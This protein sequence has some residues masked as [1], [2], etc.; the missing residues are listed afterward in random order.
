MT[1]RAWILIANGSHA[2]LCFR[3]TRSAACQTMRRFEH[4]LSAVHERDLLT[5]RPGRFKQRVGKR[6]RAAAE[7]RASAKRQEALRF[8]RELMSSV[9]HALREDASASLVLVAPPRFLG[10]LRQEL[11][12]LA[13]HRLATSI[14][15]DLTAVPDEQLTARVAALL[16]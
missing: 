7:P 14:A 2:R 13:S 15:A 16:D 8:A 3:R 6:T 1:P 9:A 11:D 12:E 4:P 10:V 5:D